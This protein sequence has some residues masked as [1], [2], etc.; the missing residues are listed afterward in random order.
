MDADQAKIKLLNDVKAELCA[1]IIRM[2][3]LSLGTIGEL[4]AL[5][6]V[7]ISFGLT[8]PHARER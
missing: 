6:G 4:A 3:D 5:I 8:T 7:E 2:P 1:A